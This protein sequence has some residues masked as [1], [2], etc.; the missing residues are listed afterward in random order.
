[1]GT[2]IEVAR[3]EQLTPGGALAIEVHG[4]TIALFR[5]GERIFAV[6]DTCTHSG[7]PLSEGSFERG[8][9]T[10]P[11]H[12]ATFDLATGRRGDDIASHDL[13]SYPVRVEGG[14]IAIE[15]PG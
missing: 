3:L 2:F 14:A 1:M 5:E 9:V 8:V 7:G 13:R 10:C 11:W 6:D 12:G 4:R 15:W